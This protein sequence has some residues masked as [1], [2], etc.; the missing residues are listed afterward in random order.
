[1]PVGHGVGNDRGASEF[2]ILRSETV[3]ISIYCFYLQ[4]YATTTSYHYT[5]AAPPVGDAPP[6]P[7][8]PC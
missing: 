1:M 2:N 5:L 7:L 3:E 6:P 8:G 4:C